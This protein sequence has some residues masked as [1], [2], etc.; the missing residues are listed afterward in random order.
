MPESA[1]VVGFAAATS[2]ARDGYGVRFK[3]KVEMSQ[4]DFDKLR[5]SLDLKSGG[6]VD[7]LYDLE[8]ARSGEWWNPPDVAAQIKLEARYKREIRRGDVFQDS[9]AMIW[10]SGV[11]YISRSKFT[12]R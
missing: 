8:R 2:T 4:S 3:A 11:A 6:L 12:A 1:R 9:V 7:P 10:I 5:A